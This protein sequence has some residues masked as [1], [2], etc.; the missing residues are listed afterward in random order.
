MLPALTLV[1]G[2]VLAQ[3]Q[4]RVEQSNDKVIE[5]ELRT[6]EDGNAKIFKKTYHSNEEMRTDEELKAFLEENKLD[7]HFYDGHKSAEPH[8]IVID[9][10]PD[11]KQQIHILSNTDSLKSFTID[12]SGAFQ[13]NGKGGAQSYAFQMLKDSDNGVWMMKGMDS[14]FTKRLSL[15][16]IDSIKE[17]LGGNFTSDGNSSFLF[18]MDTEDPES[19]HS[20]FI[21]RKKITI[22]KIEEN[23]ASLDRQSSKK[24]EKLEPL[25]LSYYPNPNNGKFTL[26]MSVK[27]A[28]PLKVSI[29]DLSGKII[30]EEEIKTFDGNYSKDF[31]LSEQP[32]GIY[33]LQVLQGKS[34]LVRK[35]MIN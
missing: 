16:D 27:S 34:R 10:S 32:S 2:T 4:V 22:S 29:M 14:T 15:I 26:K 11:R 9:G 23:E 30:H 28:D 35:I 31:D 5:V 19:S 21:I 8:T 1:L 17:V 3:K 18:Q 20:K 7:V 13:F 6:D 12:G 24:M 25:D 33:L